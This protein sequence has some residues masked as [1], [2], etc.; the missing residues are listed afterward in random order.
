MEVYRR[1][2]NGTFDDKLGG[3]N[4]KQDKDVKAFVEVDT[5]CKRTRLIRLS[6]AMNCG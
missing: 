4:V 1:S 3:W 5:H 2:V 6:L